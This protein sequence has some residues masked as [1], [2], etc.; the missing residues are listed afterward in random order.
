MHATRSEGSLPVN[1]ISNVGKVFNK[2]KPNASH[3]PPRQNADEC[4]RCGYEKH[5]EA[6][7]CPATNEYCGKCGRLGHFKKKCRTKDA[8]KRPR[9]LNT[10]GSHFQSK[11]TKLNAIENSDSQEEKVAF[12][13]TLSENHDELIN[14]K[15]AGMH[16][17]M[18]IDSGSKYNIIGSRTWARLKRSPEVQIDTE[19]QTKSLKAYA[20]SSQL[21]IICAFKAPLSVTGQ[22]DEAVEEFYVIA[23]G[24]TNLLGRDTA[25][26][27]GILRLGFPSRA[28]GI[29]Q[30]KVSEFP[31]FKGN[32]GEHK[33]LR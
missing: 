33:T 14:A 10:R 2:P 7:T 13:Y 22:D 1:K 30:I 3:Y 11:R 24:S 6:E 23:G 4:G 31:K 9:E 29:N 17:T 32:F 19:T 26:K 12:L 21:E 15:V 28:E 18:M 20:Q 16:M 25:T 27:I 8:N 5:K